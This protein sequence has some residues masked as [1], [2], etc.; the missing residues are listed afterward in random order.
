MKLNN[1]VKLTNKHQIMHKK[2]NKKLCI[3]CTSLIYIKN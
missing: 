3:K 1:K 2:L